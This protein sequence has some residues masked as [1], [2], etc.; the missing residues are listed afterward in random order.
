V[1]DVRVRDKDVLETL[2]FSRRQMRYIAKIK[3]DRPLF[4]QR[5]DVE[6]RIAGAP[7]D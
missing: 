7:I 4:K 6:R 1:V 3:H 5:F 2:N